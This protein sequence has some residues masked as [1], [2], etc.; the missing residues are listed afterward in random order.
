MSQ[1]EETACLVKKINN[2]YSSR[3]QLNLILILMSLMTY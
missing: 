2:T 3:Q 1:F